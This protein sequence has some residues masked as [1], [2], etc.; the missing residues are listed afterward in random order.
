[1]KLR[2]VLV[3]SNKLQQNLSSRQKKCRSC[4]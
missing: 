2:A 1:M 4:I 3:D